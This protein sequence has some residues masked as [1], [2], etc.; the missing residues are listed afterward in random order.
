MPSKSTHQLGSPAPWPL[1][2]S[3]R[4]KKAS[5]VC[6]IFTRGNSREL[7]PAARTRRSCLQTTTRRSALCGTSEDL[8]RVHKATQGV[9]KD[10]S[11]EHHVRGGPTEDHPTS[12]C[13]V[14][15]RVGKS[16]IRKGR[17]RLTFS[18]IL[19]NGPPPPSP[20]PN[21]RRP[22]SDDSMFCNVTKDS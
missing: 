9:G 12:A 7:L 5:V 19:A 20:F 8:R 14:R 22:I 1:S 10:A 17:I 2:F 3:K 11:A 15:K 4:S 13:F 16:G 21:A 6:P 18:S